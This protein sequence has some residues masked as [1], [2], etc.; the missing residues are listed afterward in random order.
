MTDTIHQDHKNDDYLYVIVPYFCFNDEINSELNLR[1]LLDDFSCYHNVKLVIAEGVNVKQ[2]GLQLL[3]KNIYKHIK[4][5]YNDVLWVKENLIN[6]ALSFCNKWKYAAWVD[7][8]IKFIN[9][10]WAVD[11]IKELQSKD[12][13][14]PYNRCLH[15]NEQEEFSETETEY[16]NKTPYDQSG[17]ISFCCGATGNGPKKGATMHPGQAWA[18]TRNFYT[19]IEKLFDLAIVGGGDCVIVEAIRQNKNHYAY[20]Y[21]G[22][23]FF[24]F[25]DKFKDV[26]IGYTIGTIYHRYHGKLKNRNYKTRMEL[27]STHHFN[28]SRDLK[29]LNKKVTLTK[30]GKLH[31]PFI[32]NFFKT[33]NKRVVDN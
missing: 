22:Q 24:D 10:K 26:K 19:K 3:N 31:K 18:L 27:F 30:S 9:N 4:V 7:K 5:S 1:K 6:I 25:C 2:K 33:K 32:D 17:I 23:P 29:I 11:A 8:D 28:V 13:I 14:Q 16:F 20:K 12:L 21:Y 15:L